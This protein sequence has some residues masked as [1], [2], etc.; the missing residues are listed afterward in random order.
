MK[1]IT[2][3]KKGHEFT[4]ENTY[5]YASNGKRTCRKCRRAFMSKYQKVYTLRWNEYSKNYNTVNYR[6]ALADGYVRSVLMQ[7]GLKREQIT[8]E[9]I[10]AK[11]VQLKLKRAARQL[12]KTTNEAR[13]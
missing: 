2:H 8:P 4:P 5:T 7:Q 11:R 13:P 9:I 10:E 12:M 3:C 1:A 6:G